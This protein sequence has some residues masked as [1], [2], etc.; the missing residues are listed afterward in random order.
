MSE[1]KPPVERKVVNWLKQE[2]E[3]HH[4]EADSHEQDAMEYDAAVIRYKKTGTLPRHIREY[5]NFCQKRR[6]K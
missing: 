6:N 1:T 4:A 3:D 5:Y 2:A